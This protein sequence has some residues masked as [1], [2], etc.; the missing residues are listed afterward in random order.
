MKAGQTITQDDINL[1]IFQELEKLDTK[2]EKGID[3][4]NWSIA[5]QAT[6]SAATLVI[7]ISIA[8]Y[9]VNLLSR[10]G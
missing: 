9:T 1:K 5:L 4:I 6:I 7:M 10:I 3:R 2:I 8:A